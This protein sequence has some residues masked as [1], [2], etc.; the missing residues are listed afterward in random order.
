MINAHKGKIAHNAKKV[1]HVD[2]GQIF[3]SLRAASKHFL[4]SE[5]HLCYVC[6]HNTKTK[7]GYFAYSKD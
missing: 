4:I 2:S 7:H 1:I 3:S 5:G 6:K